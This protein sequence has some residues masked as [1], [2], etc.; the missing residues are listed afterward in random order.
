MRKQALKRKKAYQRTFK[1]HGVTSK[2]LRW[3]SHSSQEIVLEN[4]ISDIDFEGK[5]VLDVGCGFGDILPYIEQKTN[6]FEYLGIDITP[7]FISEAR[8][9]YPG[10][11]FIE[12]DWMELFNKH[13][14]VICSGV[15][16][17]NVECDQYQYREEA[18]SLMIDNAREVLA[19]NMA[20]GHPQPQNKRSY[21]VYY[22]DS[23]KILRFCFQK[24]SKII[25]RHHYRN[26]DFTVAM[27]KEKS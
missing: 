2:A 4:T 16:N 11:A 8:K 13:D 10:Y 14:V 20:G 15:L 18:I 9:K 22:V 25:F 17:N 26:K 7:E 5:S 1:K 24:T 12:G 23:L 6:K 21:K 3:R 27:F 19:F